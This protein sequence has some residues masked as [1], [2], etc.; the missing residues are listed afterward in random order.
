MTMAGEQ[1]FVNK[2]TNTLTM[3]K[4]TSTAGVMRPL[5]RRSISS[6]MIMVRM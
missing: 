5:T 3:V 2:R 4:R 1:I 6:V